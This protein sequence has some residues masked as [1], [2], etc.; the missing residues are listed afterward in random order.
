MLHTVPWIDQD[1]SPTTPRLNRFQQERAHS[2]FLHR[3]VHHACNVTAVPPLHHLWVHNTVT[4]TMVYSTQRSRC[5]LCRGKSRRRQHTPALSKNTC[6]PF[7]VHIH[8]LRRNFWLRTDAW[9]WKCICYC[10]C[11]CAS[12]AGRQ[13]SR[14]KRHVVSNIVFVPFMWIRERWG[15]WV[16]QKVRSTRF[17]T[18]VS[19][20]LCQER[21]PR[22]K[23][24]HSLICNRTN[25]ICRFLSSSLACGYSK[26]S[27][28]D[29]A[30]TSNLLVDEKGA[31]APRR[32]GA[33]LDTIWKPFTRTSDHIQ[34]GVPGQKENP[35]R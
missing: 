17:A 4:M 1:H 10:P 26:Y 13:R 21:G 33:R 25:S 31:Y 2:L 15:H 3:A 5:S 22:Q 14:N 19:Y 8:P 7:P 11:S 9:A 6:F 29:D 24:F 32:V 20:G 30:S 35:Q 34:I 27:L 28:W 16:V 18:M 23:R 12:T